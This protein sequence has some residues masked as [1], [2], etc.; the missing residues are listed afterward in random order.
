MEVEPAP[1]GGW[2]GRV[3]QAGTDAQW[4]D[5]RRAWDAIEAAAFAHLVEAPSD[6][7]YLRLLRESAVPNDA[8]ALIAA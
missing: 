1:S 4:H 8:G 6:E 5:G 2:R 7:A 3:V